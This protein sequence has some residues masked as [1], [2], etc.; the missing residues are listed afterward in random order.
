MNSFVKRLESVPTGLY[1]KFSEYA[2]NIITTTPYNPDEIK[3]IENLHISHDSDFS[4]CADIEGCLGIVYTKDEV[5]HI[6]FYEF[7]NEEYTPI[8]DG[9]IGGFFLTCR[10]Q[11]QSLFK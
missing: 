1:K 3:V 6:A 5:L 10:R 11:A 4:N 9:T 2:L 7:D 8:Y